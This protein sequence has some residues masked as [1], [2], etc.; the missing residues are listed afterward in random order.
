MRLSPAANRL[1][2]CSAIVTLAVFR[3]AAAEPL[4]IH[5]HSEQAMFQVLISPGAVGTDNFVLQLMSGDGNLLQVKEAT[6]VL[7]LPERGIE[8]MQRKASLGAD[9]YWSVRDVPIPYPGRWHVRVDAVT[10]FRKITLEDDFD[11]P[12]R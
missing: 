12:A 9:G 6:L 8:P 2:L 11:V 7:S 10:A 5:I 1:L 3:P 4:A